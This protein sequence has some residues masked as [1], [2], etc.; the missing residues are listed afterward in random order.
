MSERD[1]RA[2]KIALV[3]IAL[4]AVFALVSA[5][6]DHSSREHDRQ[7]QQLDY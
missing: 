3:L 2:L 1:I 7:M 4:V 5:Y 6:V